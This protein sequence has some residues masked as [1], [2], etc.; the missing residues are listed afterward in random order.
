[1]VATAAVA[2]TDERGNPRRQLEDH[3]TG[4]ELRDG[5][6]SRSQNALRSGGAH[7]RQRVKEDGHAVA[8]QFE[9]R[10]ELVT[11][12]LQRRNGAVK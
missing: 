7:E 2:A 1:M 4:D 6:Q 9:R 8:G 10:V 5:D 12:E 11:L 3:D